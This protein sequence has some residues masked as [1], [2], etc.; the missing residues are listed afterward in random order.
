MRRRQFLAG[1][2][3]TVAVALGGCLGGDTDHEAAFREAVAADG[4]TVD[5]MNVSDGVVEF[6]YESDAVGEDLGAVA[7]A[8]ADRVA[9]G[10]S[11][12]KLDTIVHAD[13]TLT[14]YAEADWAAA[15]A[16]GEIDAA[17]YGRR[18]DE[19]MAAAAVVG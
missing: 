16:A 11:V 12:E 17:E 5:A 18:I 13:R 7:V 10:W 4:I 14:W 3:A 8:F 2:T 15:F 6:A 19:T 1:S 9:A